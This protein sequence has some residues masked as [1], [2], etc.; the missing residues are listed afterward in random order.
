LELV[1]HLIHGEATDWIPRARIILEEGET[2]TFDVFDRLAQFEKSQGKSL[3]QLLDE[4]VQLRA[5]S[6]ATLTRWQST[7]ED[8]RKEGRH[9]EF[10]A[11]TLEQLLATWTAHDLSPLAQISRVMCR[12]YT[13]AVGPWRACLAPRCHKDT[14]FLLAR[15]TW[16]R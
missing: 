12:Q 14:I 16:P 4:F 10:G 2:R 6:L 5:E 11:V 9:P 8:L 15:A 3:N 7:P 13:Q 1:G